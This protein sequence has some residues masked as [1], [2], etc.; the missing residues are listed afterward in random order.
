MPLLR[1]NRSHIDSQC[2]GD[3][4]T[5]SLSKDA[6]QKLK[7]DKRDNESYSEQIN[8]LLGGDTIDSP[9][10]NADI[11][12]TLTEIEERMKDFS[13]TQNQERVI[14]RIDDLETEMKTVFERELGR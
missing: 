4:T 14:S 10:V 9:S 13:V 12:D 11:E 6:K 8:R 1:L 5:L 2:M 3:Y 7:E